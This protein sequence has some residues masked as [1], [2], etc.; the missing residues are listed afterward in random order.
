MRRRGLQT[1]ALVGRTRGA[2]R[3]AGRDLACARGRDLPGQLPGRAACRRSITSTRRS[4]TTRESWMLLDTVCARLMRYRDRKPPQGY[5][6]V[7]EVAAA[8]PTI[9]ADGRTYTFRLRRGFRFSDGS[10]GPRGRLR[11]GDPPHP[12]P[13]RRLARLGLHAGDR[14]RRRT[15]GMEP[16]RRLRVS[17]R[18]TTPSAS[19]SRARCATS[20]PGRRCPRSAPSRRHFRQPRRGADVPRCRPLRHPRVPAGTAR[21]HPTKPL[22]RRRPRPPRRGLR[23]RPKRE[24]T[25]RRSSTASRPAK[26]TGA[27]RCLRSTSSRRHKL[28]RSTAST[29]SDSSSSQDSR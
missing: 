14:R 26:P 7:T 17:L 11:A 5:Q 9:S 2:V 13:R 6:L 27:T 18:P 20:P 15:C 10:P 19:A 25:R 28:L 29:T 21:R 8:A 4:P 24:L 16:R 3:P 12:R 22:L 23:R 1:A